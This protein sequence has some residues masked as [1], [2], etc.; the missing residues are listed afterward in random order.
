M[1]L[2]EKINQ[3]LTT[4]L[5]ARDELRLSTLRMVKAALKNREIEHRR[6]LEEA[7]AQ[8]VLST[9]IKQREDAMTQFQAGGRPELAAKEKAE[10]ELIEAYLP[11]AASPETVEATVRAVI[12]ETG[13]SSVKDMGTV[14]KASMARFQAAGERVDGKLVSETVKRLLQ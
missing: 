10:K 6:P 7:E 3:D 8:Q 9:L 1:T 14:M 2:S 13:A 5:K 4:A 12:A 11:Q